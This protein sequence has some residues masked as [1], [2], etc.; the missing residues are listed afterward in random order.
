MSIDP[1]FTLNF[2]HAVLPGCV[3]VGFFDGKTPTLVCG[4]TGGRVF[5]HT[6]GSPTPLPHVRFL[7]VNRD[8]TALGIARIVRWNTAISKAGANNSSNNVAGGGRGGGGSFDMFDVFAKSQSSAADSST[9]HLLPSPSS[10]SSFRDALL[11]G[12]ASG[13]QGYDVE[14][15]TDVLTRDLSETVASF[16]SAPWPYVVPLS[17]HKQRGGNGGVDDDG[18]TDDKIETVFV[19]GASS[20]SAISATTG[21]V[22]WWAATGERVTALCIADIDADGRPEVLAGSADAD[23][24]AYRGNDVIFEATETAAISSLCSFGVGAFAYGLANGTLGVYSVAAAAAAAAAAGGSGRLVANTSTSPVRAWRIR[25]RSPLIAIAAFDFGGSLPGAAL[26]VAALWESGH[27]EVRRAN[28]GE[29]L[30]RDDFSAPGAGLVVSPH[31]GTAGAGA[32]GGQLLLVLTQDGT[33]RAFATNDASALHAYREAAGLLASGVVEAPAAVFVPPPQKLLASVIIPPAPTP[34][35]P[36]SS[37]AVDPAAAAASAAAASAARHAAALASASALASAAAAA[38]AIS[39]EQEAAAVSAA[40]ATRNALAS[41]LREADAL[42][43]C[44][45]TATAA[46]AFPYAV[47]AAASVSLA[48]EVSAAAGAVDL[49]VTATHPDTVVRAASAWTLD[50]AVFGLGGGGGV[51]TAREAAAAVAPGAPPAGGSGESAPLGVR[52][53]RVTLCPAR[54]ITAKLRVDALL[55]TRAGAR[56]LA[57]SSTEITLPRFCAYQSLA[58]DTRDGS[59]RANNAEHIPSGTVFFSLPDVRASRVAGW[60]AG[61]FSAPAPLLFET[62][63]SGDSS[64]P[65]NTLTTAIAMMGGGEGRVPPPSPLALD[66]RFLCAR[67]LGRTSLRIAVYKTSGG[68]IVVQADDWAL[69]GEVVQDFALFFGIPSLSVTCDFPSHLRALEATLGRLAELTALRSRITGELAG[70]TGGVKGALLRAEDA[71]LRGD[72]GGSRA[73]YAQ[74]TGSVRELVR[75]Y[76]VRAGVHAALIDVLKEINGAIQKAA[77]LRGKG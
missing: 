64:P 15:N 62:G 53:L 56:L 29:L 60:L 31:M 61:S 25:A 52:A 34:A 24:R 21:E 50:A 36:P 37:A 45:D 9:A 26:D 75:E 72:P 16:A 57:V 54:D 33:A 11:L 32:G 41:A 39:S 35:A 59:F 2:G 51:G 3:A 19:G 1:V 49:I 7:N 48:I 18:V 47:P 58:R 55:G 69:A 65:P 12:S 44:L 13:L 22:V 71:R 8:V 73:H 77:A 70:A 10:S 63:E 74:V 46:A 28:T 14:D 23:L 6:G 30:F 68:A 76:D 38:A 4:T 43:M 20:L 67:T 27:F 42:G 5:L 40:L 17:D 66:A